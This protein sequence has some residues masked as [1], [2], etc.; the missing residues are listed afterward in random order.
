M[1]A[2]S[3]VTTSEFETRAIQSDQLVVV[4][5]SAAWCGPCRRLEPELEAAAQELQGKAT[6]LKVDVDADPELATRF[7]VQGIPNITF[8]KGG[9][10]V[11]KIVGLVPR[12]T[13][14]ARANAL[15]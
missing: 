9:Q 4:D 5:F 14:L 12:A 7:G 11:D 3:Q 13:I 10:V 15:L 6:V 8:L 1:S 2:V